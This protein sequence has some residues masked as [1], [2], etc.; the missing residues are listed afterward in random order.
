VSFYWSE[1]DKNLGGRVPEELTAGLN[2]F[3]LCMKGTDQ[4][5]PRCSALQGEIGSAVTCS[6]YE[7]RPSVCRIFQ[8]ASTPDP[9]HGCNIARIKWGMQPLSTIAPHG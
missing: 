3:R 4:N 9:A 5:S 1:A 7:D 8:Q 6:I 2:D